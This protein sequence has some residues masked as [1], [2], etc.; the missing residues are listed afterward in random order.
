M[1][2]DLPWR[3]YYEGF[4]RL[5]LDLRDSIILRVDP[6]LPSV[7]ELVADLRYHLE[8]I[9]RSFRVCSMPRNLKE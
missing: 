9:E 6:D 2:L 5:A 3:I 1:V 7:K 4:C 8:H